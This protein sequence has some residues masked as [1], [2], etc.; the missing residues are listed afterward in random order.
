[1]M[2]L[3]LTNW[4]FD[5]D[6]Q[7]VHADVRFE[8]DGNLLVDEPVCVDVG[9]PSLLLGAVEDVSPNRWAAADEWGKM[10]FFVCGCGDPECRGFSFV[11]RHPE[12]G[13]VEVTEVEERHGEV[14]REFDTFRVDAEEFKRLAAEAGETF[15]QFVGGLDYRPYYADTVTVVRELLARLRA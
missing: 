5:K 10:P 3:Q 6:L 11:V 13:I 2:D 1:M 4:S 12:T 8:I 7:I 15:L 9:L 14:Y